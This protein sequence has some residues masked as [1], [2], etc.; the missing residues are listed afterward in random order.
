M[1][2]QGILT[3]RAT[4][5]LLRLQ[6]VLQKEITHCIYFGDPRQRHTTGVNMCQ[7]IR[8]ETEITVDHLTPEIKLHIIT[9]N[10]RLWHSNG[11][12]SPFDDPFWAFFWPGGQAL[13][14]LGTKLL[15]LF[16]VIE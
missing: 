7:Q 2:F 11:E 6:R 9:P 3:M 16:G 5:Q 14:R 4:T 1:F 8:N 10:C 12:D 13:T 15:K